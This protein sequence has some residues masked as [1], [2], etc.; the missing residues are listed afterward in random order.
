[1]TNRLV[2]PK[3]IPIADAHHHLWDVENNIY[4]WLQETPL[5]KLVCGDITPIRKNY[6]VDDFRNDIWVLP[7]KKSVHIQC[8]WNPNDPVSETKWLQGRSDN[9]GFPTAMVAFAE[10]QNDKVEQILAGHSEFSNIRG[11]RQILNWH[12]D[13]VLTFGAPKG[14]M[15]TKAWRNGFSLLKKYNLSFD[16][17][18]YPHQMNEAVEIAALFPDTQ[19]IVNHCGMPVDRSDAGIKYWRKEMKSLAQCD[20]IAVKISGLGM[21]DHNWTTDTIRPFVLDVIDIFGIER[22]MFAS[23]FPVDKL[24]GSYSDL[25]LAFLDIVKDFT[26]TGQQALFHDNANRIYRLSGVS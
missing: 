14:V 19:I 5:P 11:I 4:P 16:L 15:K 13:P 6:L 8:D 9:T 21:T 23:N 24:Y 22:C 1:M 12:E 10:L 20:N 3:N 18:I 25:W 26:L 7:V 17:Q 2:W